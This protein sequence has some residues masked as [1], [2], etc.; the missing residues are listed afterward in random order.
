M[1]LVITL[2]TLKFIFSSSH[3]K[4]FLVFF[5]A[6]IYI[7]RKI[8]SRKIQKNADS[9][10]NLVPHGILVYFLFFSKYFSLLF[11]NEFSPFGNHFISR[12]A[13]HCVGFSSTAPVILLA[14]VLI[15]AYLVSSIGKFVS[16][17]S[18]APFPD[19]IPRVANHLRVF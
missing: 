14:K 8:C 4:F 3:E 19:V 9:R 7:F 10:N 13:N 18:A 15:N 12:V 16:S 6:T 2:R 1:K 11:F 17:F 5:Q